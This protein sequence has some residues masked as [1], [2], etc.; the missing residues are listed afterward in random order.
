MGSVVVAGACETGSG[1]CL[2]TIRQRKKRRLPRN[3]EG[4]QP[5]ALSPM[6]TPVSCSPQVK[7]KWFST[8]TPTQLV[9]TLLFCQVFVGIFFGYL[10]WTCQRSE[11]GL[12]EDEVSQEKSWVQINK[13]PA[14]TNYIAQIEDVEDQAAK[15][16]K[17]S[18]IMA[19]NWVQTEKERAFD[20]GIHGTFIRIYKRMCFYG[21]GAILG[22]VPGYIWLL[23]RCRRSL[24]A[25]AEEA[26][27]EDGFITPTDSSIDSHSLS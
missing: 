23:L 18:S 6:S 12:R 11:F 20:R 5:V 21:L 2:Q 22:T 27:A 19:H 10:V 9:W 25:S 15:W 17:L 26:A 7:R 16:R 24:A 13:L 4:L 8:T 3:T 14:V 1:L